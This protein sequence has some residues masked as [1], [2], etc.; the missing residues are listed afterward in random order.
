M[1]GE[2]LYDIVGKVM[3][4]RVVAGSA[5]GEVKVETSFQGTG[6]IF[7]MDTI[8]SGTYEAS[9]KAPGVLYGQGQGLSVTKDGDAVTWSGSG[10]GKPTGKGMAA[11]FRG[12]IYYTMQ[13]QSSPG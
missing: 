6:R 11:N 7:G 13:S 1:L 9:M 3:G 5:P 2:K 12:A 10:I 4:Q 8:E